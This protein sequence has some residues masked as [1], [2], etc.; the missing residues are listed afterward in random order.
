MSLSPGLA[1]QFTVRP[2]A[3]RETSLSF[4]LLV[5]RTELRNKIYSMELLGAG[6][7]VGQGVRPRVRGACDHWELMEVGGPGAGTGAGKDLGQ[8]LHC[9]RA[10][11]HPG[12][13]QEA[14]GE[15]QPH[16]RSPHPAQPSPLA[17][18]C[19]GQVLGKRMT[20]VA[21]TKAL[22][23]HHGKYNPKEELRKQ[24]GPH[25]QPLLTPWCSA[26]QTCRA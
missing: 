20:L 12:R 11:G 25:T 16:P 1:S 24:P 6:G 18:C 10:A 14:M 8:D 2:R 3:G 9:G 22:H 5:Y 7:L 26:L 4:C 13:P 15:S 19:P 17:P 21:M 23:I